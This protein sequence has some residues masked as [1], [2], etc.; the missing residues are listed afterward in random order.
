VWKRRKKMLQHGAIVWKK[1]K[2]TQKALIQHTRVQQ[3]AHFFFILN[4]QSIDNSLYV[5]YNAR[6]WEEQKAQRII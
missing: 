1:E 5:Y 2:T 4:K 6:Q 3:K